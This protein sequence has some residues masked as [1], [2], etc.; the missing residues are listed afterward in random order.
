QPDE[1]AVSAP[2]LQRPPRRSDD[3]EEP[4]EPEDAPLG[5]VGPRAR[6]DVRKV[7]RG[8]KRGPVALPVEIAL[9]VENV[10]VPAGRDYGPRHP[11]PPLLPRRWGGPAPPPGSPAAPAPRRLRDRE[12]RFSAH[13]SACCRS[14]RP[15]G[16]P[17]SGRAGR[18]QSSTRCARASATGTPPRKRQSPG[19]H[20]GT[21]PT[22]GVARDLATRRGSG[23]TPPRTRSGR[24]RARAGRAA[25]HRTG[26]TTRDPRPCRRGASTGLC[27]PAPA[28][29]RSPGSRPGR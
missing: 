10:E 11:P 21:L 12:G 27:P 5:E 16:C 23:R 6:G 2:D 22:G 13:R 17:S 4:L 9:V 19:H 28:A 25:G 7:A 14:A 26:R 1:C 8:L 29:P 3:I 15:A 18:A 24:S 20:S